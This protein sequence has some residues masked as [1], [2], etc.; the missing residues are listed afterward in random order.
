M[1]QELIGKYLWLV[2]VFS[3]ASPKGLSLT[4][5]ME[6]WEARWKEPYSRRSFYNHRTV[7]FDIFGVDIKCDRRS[8]QYYIDLE[9]L[10]N[11]KTKAS[12]LINSFT[13]N[14]LLA[15]SKEGLAGRVSVEEV[16]SGQKWLYMIMDSM[17][18]NEELEISYLKYTG[19]PLQKR[20]IYPYALKETA[21]RWYLVGFDV[22][23]DALRV[24]GLDRIHSISATGRH[25]SLPDDFDVDV[26]FRY[27]FGAYV[28]DRKDL[29]HIVLNATERE[30]KYLRD[31]PLHSSQKELQPGLFTLDISVTEDFVIELLGRGSRIEVLEPESLRNRL[32]E[33]FSRA[34]EL[35]K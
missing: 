6:R 23:I 27:S 31:L 12:W 26:L 30:S 13:V 20:I 34:A 29:Q 14:N 2:D 18:G 8:N 17:L 9:D 4:Q 16:P 28:S 33:D 3:N 25:F 24:Y 15:L 21:K 1:I 11:N 22:Q 19:E 10:E 7:I 5:I 32:R 35:Y